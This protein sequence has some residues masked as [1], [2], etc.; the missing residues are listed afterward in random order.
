MKTLTAGFLGKLKELT[1]DNFH[2]LA[3]Y[4]L[5][6]EFDL[7]HEAA[8]FAKMFADQYIRGENTEYE[9]TLR[10]SR[11]KRILE[12]IKQCFGEVTWKEI[13]KSL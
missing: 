12:H 13:L 9:E 5:A 7:D 1:G 11:L 4:C 2:T 10:H 3:C 6:V 8:F